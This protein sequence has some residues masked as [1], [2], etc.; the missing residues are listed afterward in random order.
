MDAITAGLPGWAIA[1]AVAITFLAG[2]VKG[3]IGFAMPLIMISAFGSFMTPAT[4]LAALIVPT[5]VTNIQQAFRFGPDIVLGK[6]RQY[7]RLIAGIVVFIIVSAQFVQVIPQ[8]L[9]LGVLGVSVIW[10]AGVQLA[11]RS[12]AVKIEHRTRAEWSMGIVGGLYGGVSGVWGPPVLVY[13]LSVGADKRETV[14]VQGIV[15]LI[16]AVVLLGAHLQSGVMN[17]E[18]IPLSAFLAIPA[19]AGMLV[20]FRLQDRLDPV[21]FRWWTLVLLLLTGMNL[22]RRAV[23]G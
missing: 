14:L 13:L 20:G 17:A 3:T 5:I 21:R 10:F 4:A 1:A 22:C 6:V 19:V 7:W 11:G 23:M 12:L 2:F 16:G 18:T 9:L 8:A 15:F